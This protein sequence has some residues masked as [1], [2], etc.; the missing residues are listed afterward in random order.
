MALKTW[1]GRALAV[2]QIT[3]LTVGGVIGAGD[4]V[5]VE[6]NRKRATATAESGDT[7]AILAGRLYTAIQA[8]ITAGT[9]PEFAEI[10]W[11]DPTIT[12]SASFTGTSAV[13][14]KPFTM[15]DGETGTS[16]VTQTATQAAT[17][18][19]HFDNAANF[20]T[21]SVL[22]GADDL[23]VPAGSPDI[24]YGLTQATA[25]A[26]GTIRLLG[27]NIGLPDR[28]GLAADPTSYVEYRTKAIE[29]ASATAIY[30]G[31]GT[32]APDFCRVKITGAVSTPIRVNS[33]AATNSTN[34]VLLNAAAGTAHTLTILGNSVGVALTAGEVME[35]GTLR[36]GTEGPEG[37]FGASDADPSVV[38]S[39]G[40]TISTAARLYGG[41][42]KSDATFTALTIIGGEW[43]QDGGTPGT[44]SATDS[45]GTYRYTGNA[46]H[47][48]ITGRG[49]GVVFDFSGDSRGFTLASG[50]S[51][52]EGAAIYNPQRI[53]CSP[54]FTIDKES[55]ENSQL[56]N[57][58]NLV[59]TAA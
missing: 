26:L 54:T 7:A 20:D 28:T 41:T 12:A 36:I 19:N 35:I 53:N 1:Q 4:T 40:V 45:A 21:N 38:L 30:I 24:L 29:F 47:G 10:T 43:S 39:T 59:L 32:D 17:G 57:S 48:V 9:A 13:A 22:V 52:T 34:S 8:L 3:T 33:G 44:V 27:G 15:T 46:S 18:P 58:I 37:S 31:D 5:W 49:E 50:S 6:I 56:G 55:I 2:P 11:V 51:I 23:L 42:V 16:T 25:L 14:G